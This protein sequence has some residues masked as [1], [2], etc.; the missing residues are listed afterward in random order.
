MPNKK[1]VRRNKRNSKRSR[2]R[3]RKGGFFGLFEDKHNTGN[4]ACD[5]NNLANLKDSNSMHSN[6]QTCCPKSWYGRK[7][8]SPYCKELDLNYKAAFQSRQN[9]ANLNKQVMTS[10]FTRDSDDGITVD[11]PI[12]CKNPNLYNTEEEIQKYIENCKC[13]NLSW[14]NYNGKKNCGIVKTTLGKLQAEERPTE[15][16]NPYPKN[17]YVQPQEDQNQRPSLYSPDNDI[18]PPPPVNAQGATPVNAE[19]TPLVNA[20]GATPVNAPT[21]E[22]DWKENNDYEP[23]PTDK[24]TEGGKR[25]KTKKHFKKRSIRKRSIRKRSIR[26]RSIRK[27]SIRKR[28]IKKRKGR[29]H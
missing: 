19:G 2:G 10:T 1:T 20:Q 3:N 13:D 17:E 18:P 6:Y 9:E 28:S 4:A 8:N 25:R 15:V 21:A 12:D 5:P 29:K 26:K 24:N 14:Y 11:V 22:V 7:N 23:D 16:T 27:R